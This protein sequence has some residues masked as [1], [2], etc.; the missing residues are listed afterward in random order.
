VCYGNEVDS[1]SVTLDPDELRDV[2]DSPLGR[3]TIFTLE[4]DGAD[5]SNGEHDHV[6]LKDF[7]FDP[8]KRELTHVDLMVVTPDRSIVVNVPIEPEGEA[9]G[10]HM[11]GRLQ[12]VH[13]DVPVRCTPETIPSS[14][15]V[16]VTPL[17]PND[18]MS[19]SDLDYPEGVEPETE[20]DY[21]VVRVMMP[22]TGVIGLET[23]TPGEEEPEEGEELEEGEEPAEGEEAEE[24]DEGDEGDEGPQDFS[25]PG[26]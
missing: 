17:G 7:Q 24:G 15:T 10:V 11:G 5:G 16:D 19:V 8:V 14:I 26:A 25:A 6:M 12:L 22:R 23:D 20:S 4:I 2:L 9:E 21:A 1:T 3:N 18:V 13:P